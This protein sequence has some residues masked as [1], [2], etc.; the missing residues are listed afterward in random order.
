MSTF[1]LRNAT[2]EDCSRILELI[3]ELALYEKA[4][5]EVVVTVEE[6][7]K[8]GF[9]PNPTWFGVV[10]ELDGKVEGI[11]LCYIRYSTWKGNV[12]YL[13][14]LIVSEPLRGKGAGKLLF[15]WC[16]EETRRRGY[17]RMAWQVL[18]WNEPSIEFY[19]R[20][21]AKLDPEWVNGTIDM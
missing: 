16:I 20:Y 15:E 7:R 3:K 4:P 21:G 19:K 8:D 14:D 10:A 11:A 9:G 2:P 6:L 5:N 12:L 17:R 18:E 13:E 1:K